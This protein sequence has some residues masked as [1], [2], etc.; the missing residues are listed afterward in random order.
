V[1]VEEGGG[2]WRNI[3]DEGHPLELKN[4]DGTLT[5]TS[6]STVGILLWKERLQ[7]QQPVIRNTTVLCQIL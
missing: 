6:A 3:A 4:P 2:I 1:N 7:L 5:Y